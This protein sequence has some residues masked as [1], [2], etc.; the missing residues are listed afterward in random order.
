MAAI[1][2]KGQDK[3][4]KKRAAFYIEYEDHNGKRRTVKGP[5][6][7]R[8]AERMAAKLEDDVHL[9]RSGLIDPRQEELA[10]QRQSPIEEHLLEFEKSVKRGKTSAKHVRLLMSRVR[11]VINGCGFKVLGDIDADAV[12]KF[13]ADFCDEEGHGHKTHNHY[14]QAFEQ[15]CKWLTNCRKVASNPVPKL[16]RLNCA[17]DIRKKRRALTIEESGKLV[18]SARN[19]GESIQCFDGETRARIYTLAYLTGLRRKELGSLTPSSFVIDVEQPTARIHATISKHR[20]VD[21][22]PLHPELVPVLREWLAGMNPDQLLF[23]KL[24]NRKTW[25]M[26]K[27]DLERVGIPYE[28]KEGVADFHAIGRHTHITQLFRSGASMTQARQ[29][30]RHSDVKTTMGYT[31]IGM[32]D[33]AQALAALPVPCQCIVSKSAVTGG[34]KAAAAVTGSHSEGPNQA[35]ASPCQM[36]SCDIKKHKRASDGSDAQKW[37]RRG[38]NP[39]PATFPCRLLRT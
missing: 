16:P 6:D 20:R 3:N 30:A 27:R 39:R 34:Q 32:E 4:K 29:L 18:E 2:Q 21:L 12:E 28:T 31:H 35:D 9:R 11:T 22:L 36:A 1:Y 5:T 24:A 15:V 37:R 13:I 8:L 23:P 26:V 14:C 25:V 17:V 33:Q 38:S 19:S 7:R 10:R